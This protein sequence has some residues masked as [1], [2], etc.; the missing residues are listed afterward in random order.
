VIGDRYDKAHEAKC[1]NHCEDAGALPDRQTGNQKSGQKERQPQVGDAAPP[2]LEA[3]A[4]LS[5]IG[6]SS[7]V[8]MLGYSGTYLL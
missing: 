6:G 2:A 3:V 4:L 7:A 5:K 8:D 1:C